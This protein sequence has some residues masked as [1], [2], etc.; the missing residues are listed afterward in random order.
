M[1]EFKNLKYYPFVCI[2]KNGKFKQRE[3]NQILPYDGFENGHNYIITVND[4]FQS[5]KLYDDYY[6]IKYRSLFDGYMITNKGTFVN[7]NGSTDWD[8][9][10]NKNINGDITVK[11]PR[12]DNTYILSELM[13]KA[14]FTKK[15]KFCTCRNF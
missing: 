4:V 6:D 15:T 1:Q 3:N 2:N 12:I 10:Y 8:I 14:F 5:V 9:E 7:E 11:F 13:V